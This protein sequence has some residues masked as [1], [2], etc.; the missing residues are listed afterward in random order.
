MDPK[1]MLSPECAKGGCQ[2]FLFIAGMIPGNH[3]L[4]KLSN[5]FLTDTFSNR[6]ANLIA[7][8]ASMFPLFLGRSSKSENL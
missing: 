4:L 8:S 1:P 3:L 5:L 6:A 2:R 7:I